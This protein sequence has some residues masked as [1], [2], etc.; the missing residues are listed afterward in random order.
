MSAECASEDVILELV[1]GQLDPA[2]RSD[3]ER[4]IASCDEC[5]K[6]VAALARTSLVG[7]TTP[8]DEANDAN[9][10]TDEADA[11]EANAP[12]KGLRVRAGDK[13]G[14]KYLVE[15]VIGQGGMGIVM[16]AMHE[17]LGQRVAIKFLMREAYGSQDTVKRLLREARAT[18]QLTSEHVTKVMD[19]GTHDDGAPYLVMEHLR[20]EDLA[21]VLKEKGP[22]PVEQALVYV[23]QACEGVAEAHA[24]GIVHRDLKPA[25]LFVTS[26][27]DGS[28]LVKVLDFGIAK[29]WSDDTTTLTSK[30]T[31]M[32]SP[33]Y[34]SPEQMTDARAVDVRS[35]VWAIGA[36]LYEL[37]SGNPAFDGESVVAVCTKVATMP[38][39]H[40]PDL[41]DQGGKSLRVL[42]ATIQR[43]LEKEPSARFQSV[44]EIARALAP[45][46]PEDAR[47]SVQRIERML[48]V[49]NGGG[50]VASSRANIKRSRSKLAL[51]TVASLVVAIF[52]A[53]AWLST[54]AAPAVQAAPS[55]SVD[56]LPARVSASPPSQTSPSSQSSASASASASASS[57]PV[58]SARPPA[59]SASS[60]ASAA[61]GIASSSTDAGAVRL[62]DRKG[63]T[64]RN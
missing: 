23:L 25:N 20:G 19:V 50:E 37:V 64:D 1:S 6:L 41:R 48:G 13:I 14:G 33:R 27:A 21:A 31:M 63:F 16:L 53:R 51:M 26:R 35:D 47:V 9:G 4:H 17:Q 42:D 30:A 45:I 61:R 54:P 10:A 18:A 56:S 59:V 24:R 2:A 34:M 36:I 58:A 8:T 32:G 29:A 11:R 60:T 15:R 12:R 7:G 40:L 39:P 52:V 62:M 43:C 57:Q 55:V 38:A 49:K 22:L 5:R 28:P 46:A 3:V 44:A